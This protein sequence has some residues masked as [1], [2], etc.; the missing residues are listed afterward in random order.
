[1]NV[2]AGSYIEE[3]IINIP[4]SLKGPNYGVN[5]NTGTRS[6]EAF[7]KP[8]HSDPDTYSLTAAVVMYVSGQL[9]VSRSMDSQLMVIILR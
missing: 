3:V 1:M 9:V 4:L 8:A 5:P 2:A 6:A 7:V